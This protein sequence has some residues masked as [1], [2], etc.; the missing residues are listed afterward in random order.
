LSEVPP[1]YEA[2]ARE[3]TGREKVALHRLR[4]TRSNES[5]IGRLDKRRSKSAKVRPLSRQVQRGGFCRCLTEPIFIV[6]T[7]F[8]HIIARWLSSPRVREL[9]R[10]DA[11]VGQATGYRSQTSNQSVPLLRVQPHRIGDALRPPQLA[12]SFYHAA[13]WHVSDVSNLSS[14][15]GTM[16]ASIACRGSKGL[17]SNEGDSRETTRCPCR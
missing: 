6:P 4:S 16:L 12:A 15:R 13:I 10:R 7:D 2:H 1:D 3:G 14:T 17:G 8:T 9:P 11:A 5:G